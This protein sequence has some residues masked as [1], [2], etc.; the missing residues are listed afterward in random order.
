MGSLP[1]FSSQM[2]P[3]RTVGMGTSATQESY[4]SFAIDVSARWRWVIIVP[5]FARCQEF[6]VISLGV[7]PCNHDFRI[8]RLVAHEED[9]VTF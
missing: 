7:L 1:W 9:C 6:V 5:T 2:Y 4:L 8:Y 3:H